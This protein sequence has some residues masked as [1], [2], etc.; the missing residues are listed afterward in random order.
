MDKL[1]EFYLNLATDASKMEQFN[2]GETPESMMVNRH[3]MLKQ[4]GID[5]SEE[6][7]TMNE[8]DLKSTLTELL[9]AQSEQWKNVNSLAPNTSNN[10]NR[11][12]SIGRGSL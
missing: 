5:S 10:D 6:L 4:A 8:D 9:S 2:Q 11:V 7:L 1:T 12:S 3:R